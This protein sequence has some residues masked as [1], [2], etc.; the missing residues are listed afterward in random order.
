MKT[1]ATELARKLKVSE[2]RGLEAVLKAEL[3]NA[4][5]KT[6]VT[7]RLTHAQ[8]AGEMVTHL[9][10]HP[11][12]AIG[13][14]LESHQHDIAAILRESLESEAAAKDSEKKC[15]CVEDPHCEK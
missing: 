4:V 14:L 2:A 12:L 10:A 13:P 5:L 15:W 11:S 8:V 6:V 1:S 7:D 3:V 9:G